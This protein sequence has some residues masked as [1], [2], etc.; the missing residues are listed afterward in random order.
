MA[1]RH[2]LFCSF[3]ISTVTGTSI[4]FSAALQCM[5][6]H[7]PVLVN[8]A[9]TSEAL[10]YAVVVTLACL[11]GQHA[12]ACLQKLSAACQCN[13]LTIIL[14]MMIIMMMIIILIM[15]SSS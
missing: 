4:I 3:F 13:F 10:C 6:R 15:L 7:Q 8:M 14:M 11:P 5:Y 12:P 1:Q 2:I 9:C